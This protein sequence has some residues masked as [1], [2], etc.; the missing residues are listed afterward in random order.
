MKHEWYCAHYLKI[1]TSKTKLMLIR[2]SKY[3]EEI[4]S[5][6]LKISLRTQDIELPKKIKYLDIVNYN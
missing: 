1:N 2:S 5:V 6:N 4:E 3:Y